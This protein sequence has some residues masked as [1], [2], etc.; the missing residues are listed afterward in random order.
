MDMSAQSDMSI[1][2]M[3]H[4]VKW[5]P[6]IRGN[7]KMQNLQSPRKGRHMKKGTTSI[8]KRV[9]TGTKT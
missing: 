8:S 2:V 5:Q 9:N 6:T 4:T 7:L 3:I 1:T